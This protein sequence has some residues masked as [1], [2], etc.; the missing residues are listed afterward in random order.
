MTDP[1]KKQMGHAQS[2]DM[3]LHVLIEER[4]SKINRNSVFD[5]HLSPTGDKWQL[6]TLFLSIFDRRSSIIDNVFDCHLS[7]VISRPLDK[8]VTSKNY[9]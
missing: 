3:L 2:R 4:R 1:S 6:K 8:S 5:C 7:G 9:F